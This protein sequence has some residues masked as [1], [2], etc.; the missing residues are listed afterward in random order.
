MTVLAL[1]TVP[2]NKQKSEKRRK[3]LP[4]AA[5]APVRTDGDVRTTGRESQETPEM[6]SLP[7]ENLRM[8]ACREL[9]AGVVVERVF[10]A[11]VRLQGFRGVRVLRQFRFTADER[12]LLPLLPRHLKDTNV[13]MKA[14]QSD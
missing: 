2:E 13:Y 7:K 8:R 1:A 6:W 10:G 9:V 14:F 4:R 5:V 11:P 12:P 3:L